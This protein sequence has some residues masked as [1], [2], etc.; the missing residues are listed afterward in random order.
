M[1]EPFSVMENELLLSD[2]VKG[3][4]GGMCSF[5]RSGGVLSAN[6]VVQC[7]FS[8]YGSFCSHG[9]SEFCR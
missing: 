4:C 5:V 1:R 7:Q 9:D 6:L 3:R 8:L 2:S